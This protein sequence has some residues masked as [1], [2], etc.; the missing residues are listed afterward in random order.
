MLA[1][2]RDMP[3][4]GSKLVALDAEVVSQL[5][6]GLRFAL[7]EAEEDVDRLLADRHPPQLAHAKRFVEGQ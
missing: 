7:G 1:S 2:K 3:I 4:A 6:T 5:E